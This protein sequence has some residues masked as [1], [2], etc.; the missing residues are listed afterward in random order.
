M[1]LSLNYNSDNDVMILGS[2]GQLGSELRK[3][4]PG[5]VCYYH[6]PDGPNFLDFRDLKKL[7]N[8]IINSKVKWIINA[9]AFTNVDMCETKKE[10]AYSVN[11][12]AVKSIVK[13]SIKIEANLVHISTDYI[14]DGVKGYYKELDVPNP[15]NYYGISKLIGETF[16]QS[17]EN[18]IVVRTSGIYGSKNNFPIYVYKNLKDHKNVNVLDGYYSPIHA[19][20]L[21][22]AIKLLIDDDMFG[23][24]NVGGIRTSRMDLALQLARKY[25]LDATLINKVDKLDSMKAV[26]P[27]DSSLDISVAKKII[28]FDFYSYESNLQCFDNTISNL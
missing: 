19:E 13:A 1:I 8:T 20:N 22:L 7:E 23:L 10:I 25:R 4:Y 14:F 21:A 16:A 27:F 24:Y 2:G 26:R 17:Y 6:S 28:N 9:A 18:S 15:L 5:A 3:L 11:S 12:L